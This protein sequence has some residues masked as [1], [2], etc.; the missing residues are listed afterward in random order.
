MHKAVAELKEYCNQKSSKNNSSSS[1]KDEQGDED[2]DNIAVADSSSPNSDRFENLLLLLG[3]LRSLQP[4]VL[5]E[6]FFAGLIGNVQIDSVV[7]Y[8]L[9]MEAS[10]YKSQFGG[11]TIWTFLAG[12]MFC[13][14][15]PTFFPDCKDEKEEISRSKSPVKDE[16]PMEETQ[17]WIVKMRK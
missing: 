5:E 16:E 6:L 17:A 11:K 8:I 2:D 13:N 4:D 3:P 14:T 9:K 15:R 7:P 1:S 12:F 10:E